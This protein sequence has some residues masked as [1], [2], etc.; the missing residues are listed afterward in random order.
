MEIPVC[1][2]ALRRTGDSARRDWR[3]IFAG[4][5]HPA[6]LPPHPA[7]RRAAAR[8]RRLLRR[9]GG[10][11]GRR[12]HPAQRRPAG[13]ARGRSSASG[14]ST[15]TASCAWPATRR[16]RRP[17]SS[18]ARTRRC[19]PATTSHDR[20]QLHERPLAHDHRLRRRRD[21]ARASTCAAWSAPTAPG[22]SARRSAPP[23]S[24]SA[25]ASRRPGRLATSGGIVIDSPGLVVTQTLHAPGAGIIVH[26][27]A[28][29]LIGGDVWSAGSD[30]ATGVD[31]SRVTS[32]GGVDLASTAGD[33]S[34][35]GAIASWGRDVPGA[36]GIE[37]GNGGPVIVGGGDVRVSGGIDSTRRARRRLL[38]RPGRRRSRVAAR[39]GIVISGPINASGDVSTSAQRLARRGRQP[40]RR[41]AA[42]AQPARSPRPA[43]AGPPRRRAGR[44]RSRSPA[45]RSRSA[46]SP[47]TPATR[48]PIPPAATAS[49]GGAVDH[50]VRR[51]RRH[52]PDLRA[53]RQRSHD[54][55]TAAPAA[56]VS[57]TGD[58]VTT[59]SIATL[60][61]ESQRARAA[62]SRCGSR[63]ALL[64][65]GAIDT[66]GAA[67][68]QRR[69]PAARGGAISLLTRTD[70]SRSAGDCAPRAAP[71]APAAP[72]APPAA[73]AARSSSSSAR[74]PPPRAC[75]AAAATAAPRASQ[76]GLR[77][78][79]GN[80]G[81]VRVWAQ[82]PSLIL[83]QLVDS[84]GGT[85]D[86]ERRRRPA[87]S[88]SPHRRT[89][90]VSK[91]RV[92]SWV[93]HSPG[94][95]GLPAC[96]SAS[97]ARRSRRCMTT[98]A[99]SVPLPKV[100]RLRQG[101]LLA[102]RVPQ[103]HRLA[104]R[105]ARPAQRRRCRRRRRRPARTRR[106]S[107]SWPRRSRRRSSR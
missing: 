30:T 57:I 86:P 102:R 85:G 55:A 101:R 35:L 98:K 45:R 76:G 94:R 43:R 9:S 4:G 95:R 38:R 88:R 72:S 17:T 100:A 65:G 24:R 52:G 11:A 20:Q 99:A 61:G 53:R 97:P 81:A 40:R 36:G 78:R 96:S 51:R 54:R 74:S 104:Q 37:G 83:L 56:V 32:G 62:A 42:I 70:R 15:S 105:P 77:G 18:S 44:H 75:S 71:G 39:G 106:R 80:G 8:L 73:T 79:G 66:S 28:G 5:R 58:R 22:G 60:G 16:S 29:V 26:G 107:R 13:H 84:G 64:V 6:R 103:R 50:Q 59:G 31:P 34:V 25:A 92:L 14:C 41:P 27:G 87:E 82:L 23:A 91:T 68:R 63:R 48:P 10:R 19:R 49:A 46:R 2:A 3:S 21:L 33:V 47:P 12:P 1:R 89:S 7:L 93:S 90:R 67:G 69:S